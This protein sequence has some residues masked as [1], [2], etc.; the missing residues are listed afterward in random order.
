MD[1]WLCKNNGRTNAA[2]A[3]AISGMHSLKAGADFEKK[4]GNT[5][6]NAE[7]FFLLFAM[8]LEMRCKYSLHYVN[9]MVLLQ[10]NPAKCYG[11]AFAQKLRSIDTCWLFYEFFRKP[12]IR[13][14]RN[15]EFKKEA[16]SCHLIFRQRYT[17][18]IVSRAQGNLLSGTE[19]LD[20][21]TP[22]ARND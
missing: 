17:L 2:F 22:L 1:F 6:S 19:V 10:R 15:L 7:T 21:V 16:A 20:F 12:V 9:V 8:V 11:C 3:S 4:K 13:F 18:S 14:W 5:A